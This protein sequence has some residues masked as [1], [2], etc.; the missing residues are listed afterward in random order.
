MKFPICIIQQILPSSYGF[1]CKWGQREP[2]DNNTENDTVK[3]ALTVTL[4]NLLVWPV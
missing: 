2:K 1:C 3:F 4:N